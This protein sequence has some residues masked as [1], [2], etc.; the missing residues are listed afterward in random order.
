MDGSFMGFS[1]EGFPYT[2]ERDPG[3]ADPNFLTMR[4]FECRIF[5]HAQRGGFAK[6]L[7]PV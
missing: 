7:T 4:Y 1:M 6:N 2:G 3:Q 5:L